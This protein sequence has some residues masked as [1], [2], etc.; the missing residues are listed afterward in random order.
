M[1]VTGLGSMP[2]TDLREAVRVVRD[3]V[4]DIF[5][6]P[7]LPQRGPASSMIGRTLGVLEQPCTR[8]DDGWRL[9]AVAGP[10][11]VRAARWWR[12][13]L[14]DVE[15][16]TQGA[17]APVKVA[18]AGP[19]T[20]AASVRL[21]HPT[22]DHAL[23]DQGA[24]HDIAQALAEGIAGKV[25][26]ISAR[27]GRP[28]LVQLDEP[29]APAVLGG[30]LP[31]FSGLHRYRVPGSDEVLAAWRDVTGMVAALPGVAGLWLHCCA[32][33]LDVGLVRQA[34]FTGVSLD[35]RYVGGAQLDALGEWAEAG[36]TFAFGVARTDRVI[37]PEVDQ[38][39]DASLGLLRRFGLD[40]DLLDAGV[41]LTPAC[42][43]GTWPQAAARTL[44]ER[45]RAA[46][47]L[48]AEQ[49]HR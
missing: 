8:E 29:A 3:L 1:K 19:W 34:G 36:G 40:P 33:G 31:T 35:A 12:S 21:A 4:P 48:V 45:L 39:V 10:Q 49:L 28:L 16:L 41:V 5:A 2:G 23:A 15:E 25:A 11:Q 42:G 7:E 44:L 22:M 26:A 20:L 37:V 14:D 17:T 18:F 32:P 43:L 6:W 47:P 9:A 46:A 38:L 27:L 24:C 30:T 13:D